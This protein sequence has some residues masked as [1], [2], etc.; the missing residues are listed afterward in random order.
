MRYRYAASGPIIP[1]RSLS[2]DIGLPPIVLRSDL[3][4][5]AAFLSTVF[6]C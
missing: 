1:L 6:G 5:M 2:L 3:R 4:G